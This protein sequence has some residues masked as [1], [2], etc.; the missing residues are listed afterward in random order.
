MLVLANEY[1]ETILFRLAHAR[2]IRSAQVGP[3]WTTEKRGTLAA[4]M[5]RTRK[6]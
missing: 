3:L 6:R 5:N 4:A 1:I 2:G